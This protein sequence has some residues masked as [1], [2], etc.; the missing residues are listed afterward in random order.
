[1]DLPWS[2]PRTSIF[3]TN[4]GL[5]TSDGPIGPNIMAAEWTHQISYTPGLIAIFIRSNHAT[6]ENIVAQGEFGVNLASSSQNVIASIAGNDTGYEVDKIKVLENLGVTFYQAKKIK[7]IMLKGAALNAECKLIKQIVLG[8]HNMFVG[9][10]LEVSEGSE[11]P[12][13]Y[14]RRKYWKLE[15]NIPKPE[16]IALKKI[17]QLIQKYKKNAC[18]SADRNGSL[19]NKPE[20]YWKNKLTPQ[21]YR[22]CRLKGT[23][24]QFT[25]KYYTHKE[26][27]IYSCVACEQPLFTSEGKFDS[28]TGW[29]SFFKPFDKN[30]MVLK[31]DTSLY[32][33]RIEA[34]CARCNSHL[35]HV[36]DDGPLPTGKR[37]CINSTALDFKP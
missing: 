34:I 33:D 36:F 19:K 13:V 35:G 16:K 20:S 24:A 15:K 29:P 26:K 23:E 1:M 22:V 32:M 3:V 21:Q 2:D 30:K 14:Y 10:I 7:T 8:D 5:I 6:A 12:L 9:E 4:V 18:L 27:G 28:G 17:D 37:Y 31:E 25:G 11:I